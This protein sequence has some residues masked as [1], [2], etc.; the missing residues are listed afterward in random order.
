MAN[1]AYNTIMASIYAI[2][3]PQRKQIL[4]RPNHKI[5]GSY[6]QDDQK[7]KK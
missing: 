3:Q 5:P 2:A 1:K 7:P 6:L 4:A